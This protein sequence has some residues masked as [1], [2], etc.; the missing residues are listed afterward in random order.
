MSDHDLWHVKLSEGCVVEMTLD[1]IDTAFN[2]GRINARTSVMPPGD[3]HWTTLGEAA[4]LED[5]ERPTQPSAHVEAAPYSIAPVAADV[6]PQPPVYD[7]GDGLDVDLESN[8]GL[9]RKRG[10][11]GKVVGVAVLFTVLIAAGIGGGAYA[12]R[13]AEFKAKVASVKERFTNKG[14]SVAAAAQPPPPPVET[15]APVVP[16]PPPAETAAPVAATPQPSASSSAGA[17]SVSS[18]PDAK[19]A[20]KSSAKKKK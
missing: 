1:E 19:G 11:F 3:F 12:A 13:P 16:P 15:A 20:K 8:A 4:G 9:P 7:F 10:V 5:E 14:S 6:T 2:A 17:M 18:L